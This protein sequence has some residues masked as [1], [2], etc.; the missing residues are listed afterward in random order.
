MK[1]LYAI[2]LFVS[3]SLMQQVA[4]AQVYLGVYGLRT[5]SY[6]IK[7]PDIGGGFGMNILS[8]YMAIPKT[9]LPAKFQ[10]GVDFN[11][12][13]LGHSTF[14]NVPLNS[15]PGLAKATLSN[16]IFTI[17]L[18]GQ[19]SFPYKSRITPYGNAFLGYRGTFSDLAITPNTHTP[20][21]E[22]QTNKSISSAHGINYG[23]GAGFLTRIWKTSYLDLGFMY[24]ETIGG[25]RVADL[26]TAYSNSGG[27]NLNL[28]NRPNALMMIKVGFVFY[29]P[30]GKDTDNDDCDCKCKHRHRSTTRVG[31]GSWGGWSGGGRSSGVNINIGGGR[32]K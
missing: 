26:N 13:G 25:G 29:I 15:Q 12:S 23:V 32:A 8:D 24:N 7:S 30:K 17:N 27:I 10:T 20:G 5:N 3:I 6:D 31:G 2:T 18:I 14:Q 1:K 21:V 11:Y 9:N 22:S 28:K 16:G 4:L 19:L